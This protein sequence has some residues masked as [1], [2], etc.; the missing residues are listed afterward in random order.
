MK[1]LISLSFA[2]FSINALTA[3]IP[4]ASAV[5]NSYA[6]EGTTLGANETISYNGISL[7]NRVKLR[8][9]ADFILAHTN[10]ETDES[11]DFS[12]TADLDFLI[13]VSPVTA[14]I[15]LNLSSTSDNGEDIGLEQAFGRYSFNQNFHLTF[16][17]QLTSLGFDA[18]ESPD[19][20]AVTSAYSHDQKKGFSLSNNY[21][22]GAR[23]NYNNGKFGLIFGLHDTYGWGNNMNLGEGVAVDVAAS[24][25]IIS[26]LE[27]QIGFAHEDVD[28]EGD[29]ISQFNAFLSYTNENL[30]LGLEHDQYDYFDYALWDIMALV[31]Y[32]FTDWFAT[33]LRYSYE[34]NEIVSLGFESSDRFSLAMLFSISNN[35]FVNL[36]YSHAEH[37]LIS[38]G[39]NDIDEI[40]LEGLLT[41]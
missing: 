1:Y 8:G 35:L 30:T 25:M 18:D 5:A 23:L 37:K 41:F 27:G 2:L 13:D 7:G 29:S 31:N 14:E 19:L 21:V 4:G 15:H 16:G 10:S 24:V 17:R 12:T 9:Y 22:D 36:E 40:Y 32:S 34:D 6:S 20:F 28:D 3:Q 26:G 39:D 33:T 38:G 11:A